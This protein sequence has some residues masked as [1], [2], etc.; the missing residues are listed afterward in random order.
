MQI[1]DIHEFLRYFD[2][3]RRRTVRV[4]ERI[5]LDR[6]EWTHREGAFTLGDLVRHLGAAERYM[7]AENV[8]GLPSRYP[9]CGAELAQGLDGVLGFLDEMHD[10]ASRVFRALGP[11]DLLRP[12]P[13]PGGISL[14]TWKWLRA[15]VEHEVHH[16]GQMYTMLGILGVETPPLYGLT[17]RDV[18]AGSEPVEGASQPPES[19]R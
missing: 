11:E 14:P 12:C 10:Q 2:R 1:I 8:Q 17:E 18:F 9:G 3:V 6:V 19:G 16:R 7:W 4:A 13:T 15:M 5:P